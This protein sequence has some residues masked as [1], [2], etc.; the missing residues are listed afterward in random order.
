M[1]PIKWG[2][3]SSPQNVSYGELPGL[4]RRADALGYDSAWLFDHFVPIFSDPS[5]PCF[6]GW[7]MLTAL[8]A[9]TQR[10]HVGCLVTAMGYRN[11]GVLAK[12]GATLD[13]ISGGR[14]EL[15]IGAGWFEAEVRAYGITFP[16]AK[17]RLQQLDEGIQVIQKLWTQTLSDFQG[18]HFNLQQARCEPKPV[19][20]PHP[21]IWI[22]GQG[23]KVTL[24]IVAQRADG[25]DMDMVPVE[26]YKRK[27]EALAG[28][29][30]AVG[31]NPNSVQKMIHFPGIIGYHEHHIQQRAESMARSWN[32]DLE[33]LRQRVLVGTP[34]Q[35][36]AQLRPFRALG[37]EHF[38]LSVSPPYDLSMIELFVEEV[39]ALVVA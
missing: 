15:G 1:S 17:A 28:H 31:R 22:G 9:Q 25:W 2:L 39:A 8:A 18:M 16:D 30:G 38:V 7:T 6:E 34:E 3:Q 5:G 12:M 26:E 36:A 23:E 11:P 14:L 4:W 27:L 29:C 35:A 33:G 37:V 10:L 19:Q 24:R 32:T 13:V 21:R 20:R